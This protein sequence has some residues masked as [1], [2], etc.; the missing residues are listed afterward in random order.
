[1]LRVGADEGGTSLK[2]VSLRDKGLHEEDL[3]EWIIK[4]PQEILGEDYLLIGREVTVKH[5]GDA[6]DLLA[7]DR[8]G[9]IVAIEL[10][11]GALKP[12][13]DFQGLKYAAYISH[14]DYSK[15]RDQFDKFKTTSWGSGIYDEE[16]TFTEAL[17]EFCNEDYTLNQDQRIVFVGESVRERLDI[18]LRWLSDR[19]ID[20]TV[21]EFQLLEDDD[22]LYLD[23]EQTIPTPEHTI[24]DVSPDTSEEPW[25]EDGRSWHLNERS[26]D[27]T[28]DLLERV[29]AALEELEF[30]DGPGWGQKHYVSFVQGRKRRIAIRTKRTLFHVDVYD[31]DPTSVDIEQVSEQLGI[32]IEAISAEEDLRNSGRSGVRITCKPEYEAN[33]DAFESTFRGIFGEEDE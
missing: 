30:L 33:L 15:L 8:D 25:K 29:A 28:A 24:S 16:L 21:I 27:Q 23:A 12:E 17:D 22:R 9:N 2:P 1:M 3:R 11:R 6:I 19:S 26:N 31:V 7:I 5:I 10:K 32:P 20:I 4:S 18:V 13:V 14:W